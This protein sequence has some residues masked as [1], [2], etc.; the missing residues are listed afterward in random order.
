MANTEK[1][2]ANQLKKELKSIAEIAL[3]FFNRTLKN[4]SMNSQCMQWWQRHILI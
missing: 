4:H 2:F 3:R 1:S